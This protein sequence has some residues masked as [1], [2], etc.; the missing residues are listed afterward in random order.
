VAAQ[1][2]CSRASKLLFDQRPKSDRKD[3]YDLESEFKSL[4]SAVKKGAP[5]VTIVGLRRTGKTSL[6]MTALNQIHGSSITLDLRVLASKPY[7]TKRDLIQEI[8]RAL[9]GFYKA[10]LS[11]GKRLFNWLKR[12]QGVGISHVGISISWGGKEPTELAALFDELNAWAKQEKT[13]M[14]VAFDEAQELKKVAGVDMMKLV[15]HIYDYCRNI[16]LV[17]TGS[18]IGLLYD[19]LGSQDAE[20]PLYGREV[21]EI[22]LNRLSDEMSTDFLKR[23]FKQSRIKADEK[24]VDLAVKRLGGITGWLTLFGITCVKAGAVSES[25]ID[26]TVEAGKSLAKHEFDNF[27]KGREVAKQRYETII[28]QLSRG[29]SSWSAIKGTIEAM[30][31][32]TI[33]DRNITDLVNTLVK[34]GFV[35]KDGESYRLTDQMLAESFK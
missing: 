34:A 13:R 19:F 3:L 20:A 12:V 30:E 9:N 27:L 8:E 32:K 22:R 18:A 28:Q 10:H 31:G 25:A 24:V 11:S 21:T 29:S 14:V 2:T 5:L 1:V 23:G 6:L 35:E 15:A 7:A 33:N 4:L 17:M 16:T 26:Q